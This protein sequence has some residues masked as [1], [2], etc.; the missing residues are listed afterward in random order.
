MAEEYRHANGDSLEYWKGAASGRLLF[1]KCASCGSVQFPPRHHCAACWEADLSWVEST[2]KGTIESFTVVRRAPLAAF[3]D[4]VPYV[5]AAV[6][7]D[8]G[9]R[10]LTNIVGENA[11]DAQ[12]GASVHVTFEADADGTVLPRFVLD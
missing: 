3:R 6:L 12:I 1:Q 7:V 9:P 4:Q 5:V 10:M 8:E 2:G 11:L